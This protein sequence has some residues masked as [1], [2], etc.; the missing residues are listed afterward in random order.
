MQ[1]ERFSDALGQLVMMA[2]ESSLALMCAEARPEDC[3]R[4]LLSDALTLLHGLDVRH[5]LSTEAAISHSV[6]EAARVSMGRVQYPD[7]A[8]SFDF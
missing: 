2:Q 7:P 1:T 4:F 8:L 6:S 5:L 3:H